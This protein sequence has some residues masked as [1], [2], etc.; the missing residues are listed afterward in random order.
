[1]LGPIPRSA[2]VLRLAGLSRL[3]IGDPVLGRVAWGLEV[4]LVCLD[5]L[6]RGLPP[7]CHGRASSESVLSIIRAAGLAVCTGL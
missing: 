2:G 5:V 6:Q 1:M 7:D 4:R 3:E